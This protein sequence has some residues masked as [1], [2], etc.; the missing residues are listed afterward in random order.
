MPEVLVFGKKNEKKS[1]SVIIKYSE[2]INMGG[3]VSFGELVC[4]EE[5]GNHTVRSPITVSPWNTS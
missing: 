2:N 1:Y 3:E 5:K 4:V